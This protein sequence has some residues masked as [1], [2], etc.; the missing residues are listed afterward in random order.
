MR[1]QVARARALFEAAEPAIAAAPAS[2]RSGMRIAIRAYGRVLER[3]EAAGGDVL[4]RRV[5]LRA[6]DL[7]RIALAAVRP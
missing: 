5:T 7:P 4:G 2:A 6:W 1:Q 3:A